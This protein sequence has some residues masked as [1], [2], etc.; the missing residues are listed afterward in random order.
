MAVLLRTPDTGHRNTFYHI[1]YEKWVSAQWLQKLPRRKAAIKYL[2]L[3]FF[4]FLLRDNSVDFKLSY[5]MAHLWDFQQANLRKDNEWKQECVLAPHWPA[6]ECHLES[7]PHSSHGAWS[8]L[9]TFTCFSC[10]AWKQHAHPP[11]LGCSLQCH[12]LFSVTQL[13]A[14]IICVLT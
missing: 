13:R 2:A 14:V 3:V 1:Q 9:L 5:W 10:W 12:P 8:H 11:Q 7:Q 4:F 6:N